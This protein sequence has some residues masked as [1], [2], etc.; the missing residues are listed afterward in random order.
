MKSFPL[1]VIYQ[2]LPNPFPPVALLP[3]LH[4]VPLID[5]PGT[6]SRMF[7]LANTWKQNLCIPV[8]SSTRI[9]EY[10]CIPGRENRHS[11]PSWEAATGIEQRSES[12]CS[13]YSL[14]AGFC[15]SI[16]AGEAGC[17]AEGACVRLR[18]AEQSDTHHRARLG[19]PALGRHNLLGDKLGSILYPVSVSEEFA[20][21]SVYITVAC[22]FS[23]A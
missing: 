6:R 17:G 7:H 4:R 15:D 13:Q 23:E 1:R 14:P 16:G 22:L 10:T 3:S 8:S 9:S 19:A 11:V 12:C 21:K 2:A 18:A 20:W 5:Q